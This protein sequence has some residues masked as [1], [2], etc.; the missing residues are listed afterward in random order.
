MNSKVNN[1]GKRVDSA[2]TATIHTHTGNLDNKGDCGNT[3]HQCSHNVRC[4][5]CN[6]HVIFARFFCHTSISL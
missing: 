4:S 1:H 2:A 5:S 3:C 6:V